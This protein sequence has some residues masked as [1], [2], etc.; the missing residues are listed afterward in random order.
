VLHIVVKSCAPAV[1]MAISIEVYSMVAPRTSAFAYH[2][3][4]RVTM[5][6]TCHILLYDWASIQI[7]SSCI[8][9]TV[10]SYEQSHTQLCCVLV[11]TSC[12]RFCISTIY[13]QYTAQQLCTCVGACNAVILKAVSRKY[14]RDCTLTY[15]A[16]AM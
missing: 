1:A 12:M 5:T 6:Y 11:K 14:K 8:D 10:T 4:Y 13:I 9:T 3:R 7:S 16:V 2:V 15:I